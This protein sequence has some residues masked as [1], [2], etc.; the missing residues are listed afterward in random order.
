[1]NI[2]CYRFKG[3]VLYYTDQQQ[4]ETH[5]VPTVHWDEYMKLR[6]T[7]PNMCKIYDTI[8]GARDGATGESAN[9]VYLASIKREKIYRQGVLNFG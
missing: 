9:H 8:E 1:M 3:Q 5:F 7:V 4:S 6:K 2:R